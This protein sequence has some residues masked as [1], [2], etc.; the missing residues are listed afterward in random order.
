MIGT[1]RIDRSDLFIGGKFVRAESSERVQ[2]INPATEEVVGSVPDVGQA[3]L[4]RAVSAAREALRGWRRTTGAERATLLTALAD[5]YKARATEMKVLLTRENGAPKW[6]A[7][8]DVGVAELVYRQAAAAAA[9]LEQ[10]QI[11]D[12]PAGRTLLRH[13]PVG[14]VGAIAPWNSPQALLA[15]KVANAIAA[16]C[17]VVAKPSPETSLDTYLLAEAMVEAGLPGGVMNIVSGGPATG[18]ALVKH[19]DVDKISFTGSTESGKAVGA[20]CARMLKPLTAELGGKSAAVLLDDADLQQFFGT[21]QRE[22]LPFSGQACFST[23][24]IIV[25]RALHDAVVEGAA[26]TLSAMRFGDPSDPETIMGPLVS[27]RQ[28]DR[29]EGYLRSGTEQG[30][31]LALGGSRAKSFDTGY[32]I[33]PTIF[34][35]VDPSMKIFAEEIFGP[36]MVVSAY[37]TEKE[38]IALHDA[39]NF[40]LS[41]SV[42][43]RDPQ[44]ATAFARHLATGQLLINGKRSGF[45]VVRDMYKQSALGGG[46][47]RIAGF[48]LRKAISQ[49]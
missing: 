6:W 21:I 11:V 17:T 26:A 41:G 24:R 18:A 42:F 40:G 15:M 39:T 29:V 8:Q 1:S 12:S 14:V 13:E 38:A 28:R 37:D 36:V 22:C 45:S 25:P 20:E 30:A 4:D 47:D 10:E 19:P 48:Q 34:I 32:Y 23:T 35:K 33:A 46:V 3:D 44:R 43:S 7:E 16:G 31:R 9:K 2:A 5:A 27:A 49:P